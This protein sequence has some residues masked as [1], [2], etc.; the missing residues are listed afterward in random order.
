MTDRARR[1]AGGEEILDRIRHGLE[2]AGEILKAFTPGRI[3]ARRKAGG[4]PVTEAD[5]AVD[6]AL[7]ETLLREG[8][9]WLSEE[10]AD[11]PDRLERSRVWVVDPLDGTKEFVSGI[12]E[13]CVS[14]GFVEEGEAVAGGIYNRCT[15]QM[16]IGSLAAG[17]R[18]NEKPVRVRLTERLE[19]SEIL[20]SRTEVTKGQWKRFEGG[21]FSIRPMGSVAYKLSLVAAGLADA[22]WTLVPKHEWDVAAGVALVRAAGGATR[23]LDWR[24]PVFNGRSPRLDGLVACGPRLLDEI[25][26]Y[27]GLAGG[28]PKG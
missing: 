26:A 13:W 4:H 12:P 1:P 22:T 21:D 10:T 17:V 5:L 25:G 2:V 16:V 15:G 23:T 8:E 19:G 20:A 14:I 27:L 3:E 9:G 6:R 11:H 18:L 24:L 7:R 28:S